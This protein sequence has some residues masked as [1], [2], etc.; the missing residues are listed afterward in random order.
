MNVNPNINF[1]H[2]KKV[3]INVWFSFYSFKFKLHEILDWSFKKKQKKQQQQ[4]NIGNDDTY[5]IGSLKGFKSALQP[6][7]NSIFAFLPS[8]SYSQLNDVDCEFYSFVME[9]NHIWFK[10]GV[11]S[12]KFKDGAFKMISTKD[13]YVMK[14]NT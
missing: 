8:P 12:K 9:S 5:T 13:F 1:T 10:N 2:F 14:Q 6:T 3:N 7:I 11:C 4:R